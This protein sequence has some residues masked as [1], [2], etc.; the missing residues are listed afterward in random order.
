MN[1]TSKCDQLRSFDINKGWLITILINL[2]IYLF[3]MYSTVSSTPYI[4]GVCVVVYRYGK[5][6]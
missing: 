1:K 2:F 5:K 3:I 4:K 6:R